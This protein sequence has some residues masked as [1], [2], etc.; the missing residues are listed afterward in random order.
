MIMTSCSNL[1]LSYRSYW[2]PFQV[3]RW[4]AE[5]K[6]QGEQLGLRA[7]V[8]VGWGVESGRKEY[9]S[10]RKGDTVPLSRCPR[11]QKGSVAQMTIKDCDL[12][13]V[14]ALVRPWMELDE[15]G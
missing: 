9:R 6:F 4:G 2:Q 10:M 7:K 11:P 15:G 3:M 14:W 1:I 13:R 12:S 5:D 8:G